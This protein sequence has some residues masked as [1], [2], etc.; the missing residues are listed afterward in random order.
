MVLKLGDSASFAFVI[1]YHLC[2]TTCKK[3]NLKNFNDLLA[4]SLKNATY[5]H[6]LNTCT[7][8]WLNFHNKI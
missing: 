7:Q 4:L 5:A 3:K 1:G 2:S 8:L 6:V